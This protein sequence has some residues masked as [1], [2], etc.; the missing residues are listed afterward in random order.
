MHILAILIVLENLAWIGQI[1]HQIIIGR[2]CW[3]R[4]VACEIWNSRWRFTKFVV[5]LHNPVSFIARLINHVWLLQKR[6][7]RSL[8]IHKT[9]LEVCGRVTRRY[10]VVLD[11]FEVAKSV[12]NAQLCEDSLLVNPQIQMFE[13]YWQVWCLYTEK[14]K[15]NEGLERYCKEYQLILTTYW[16]DRRGRAKSFVIC[17]VSLA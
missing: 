8:V 11:W 7:W 14:W 6:D 1:L 2:V 3:Q 17:S 12:R 10:L 9:C 5:L 4:I 15:T 13:L 16:R